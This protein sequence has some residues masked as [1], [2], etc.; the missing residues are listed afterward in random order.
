MHQQQKT[1][2]KLQNNFHLKTSALKKN[3]QERSNNKAWIFNAYVAE[4]STSH[5]SI[6][7]KIWI[8]QKASINNRV[9]KL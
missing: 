1:S 5:L 7:T 8:A 2:Y 9:L 6:F 3:T 4:D